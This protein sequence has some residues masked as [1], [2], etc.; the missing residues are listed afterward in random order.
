MCVRACVRVLC[1]RCE[2]GPAC[3]CVH[4]LYSL[5]LKWRHNGANTLWQHHTQTELCR[6]IS[7]MPTDGAAGAIGCS[8]NEIRNRSLLDAEIRSLEY[9]IGRLTNRYRVIFDYFFLMLGFFSLICQHFRV[10]KCIKWATAGIWVQAYSFSA[11]FEASFLTSSSGIQI[12]FKWTSFSGFIWQFFHG[13]FLQDSKCHDRPRFV[14]RNYRLLRF[15]TVSNCFAPDYKHL[16]GS[17]D[18]HNV[19]KCIGKKIL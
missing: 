15:F 5:Y 10:K 16:C 9:D 13:S 8:R 11:Y 7:N 17:Y 18:G 19:C 12:S 3:L 4:E 14:L 1:V 2:P 6:L